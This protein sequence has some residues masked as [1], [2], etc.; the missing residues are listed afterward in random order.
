[1]KKY[2]IWTLVV[3][4]GLVYGL[5]ATIRHWRLETGLYD[6]GIYEQIVWQMANG[7]KLFSTVMGIHPW[8]D[9]FTPSLFSIALIYKLWPS[10]LTLLLFQVLVIV[11][12]AIPI[13]LYVV[14]KKRSV[15]LALTLAGTYLSFWGVQNAIDFDFHP[16]AVGSALLSWWIWLWE[17]KITGWKFWLLTIFIGGWQENMWL[18]MTIISSGWLVFGKRRIESA[19]IFIVSILMLMA[20]IGGII[21]YFGQGYFLYS[22]NNLWENFVS[23]STDKGRVLY[24]VLASSGGLAFLNPLG[25]LW[26]GGELF[27]RFMLSSWPAR[28]TIW[29]QYNVPLAVLTIWSVVLW[30][31]NKIKGTKLLSFYLLC[32]SLMVFL[33]YPAPIK[34]LLKSDFYKL[35]VN[36]IKTAMELIPANASVATINNLGAQMAGREKV[37][38]LTHCIDTGGPKSKEDLRYC[39]PDWPDYILVDY[40]EETN[41]YYPTSLKNTQNKIDEIM[42]TNLYKEIALN[43]TIY[44]LKKL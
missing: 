9:H 7:E 15:L 28:W 42:K 31:G 44:L 10:A 22:P 12:A 11:S 32:C 26:I 41:N 33:I 35:D 21:P 39:F 40:K 24:F 43:K 37:Y 4:F 6:L 18:L 36:G 16:L 1:M 8:G 34:K 25:W 14:D 29:Y 17:K 5:L 13:Y 20:V 30:A 27:S 2:G 23:H 38:L 3:F 19:K